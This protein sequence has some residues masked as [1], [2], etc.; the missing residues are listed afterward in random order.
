MCDISAK[1]NVA[2]A[3]AAENKIELFFPVEYLTWRIEGYWLKVKA[4]C[5]RKTEPGDIELVKCLAVD[6]TTGEKQL[7]FYV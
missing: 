1:G 5:S 3:C 6:K 7:R 4:A 2:N